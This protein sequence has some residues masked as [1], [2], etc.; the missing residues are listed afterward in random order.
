MMS[1]EAIKA[2]TFRS[3]QSVMAIGSETMAKGANS[4]AA[5]GGLRFRATS[6]GLRP[7][8]YRSEPDSH[9]RPV[10]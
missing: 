2:D 8:K 10:S 5:T 3:I 7:E 9:A 1:S 4:S 6:V